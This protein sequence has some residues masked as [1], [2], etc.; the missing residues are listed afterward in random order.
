[1]RAGHRL[2]RPC[3]PGIAATNKIRHTMNQKPFFDRSSE[4]EPAPP[5]ARPRI[6]F[7]LRLLLDVTT[8]VA[9]CCTTI[10]YLGT[11]GARGFLAGCA[12]AFVA[13]RGLRRLVQS[14]RI[15]LMIC[16]G[17]GAV[18]GAIACPRLPQL[19]AGVVSGSIGGCAFGLCWYRLVISFLPDSGQFGDGQKRPDGAAQKGNHTLSVVVCALILGPLAGLFLA[20]ID[21]TF[22][23]VADQDRYYV[24]MVFVIIGATAGGLVSM[25]F[26]L[27][28]LLNNKEAVKKLASIDRSENEPDNGREGFD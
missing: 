15:S 19:A 25:P 20:T 24:M 4:I 13:V 16:V 6:R 22:G 27:G 8:L 23:G 18:G 11:V 10:G 12:V 21:V 17:A 9:I 28:A 2:R 3:S 1:M 5:L 14:D 7:T 26:L